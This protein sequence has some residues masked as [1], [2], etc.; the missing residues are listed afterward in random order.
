MVRA[1]EGQHRPRAGQG[2]KS[3]DRVRWGQV[4]SKEGG[5]VG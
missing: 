2:E 5:E 4:E 1:G 3:E